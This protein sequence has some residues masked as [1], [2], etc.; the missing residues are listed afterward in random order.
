MSMTDLRRRTNL[1]VHIA[2]RGVLLIAL[3]IVTGAIMS[4]LS[5]YF[6]RAD[7]LLSMTQYGTIIGLLALGQAIVILGGGG[8]IDLSIGS[9][10]SL[11]AVAMGLLT[12]DLG[13]NPWLAA[14]GAIV[15]GVLLGAFNGVLVAVVGLPP[16]IV[17][18][19]TL[20]VYGS[21]A[22]VLTG[23]G[24]LGGFDAAGFPLLG[25]SAVLGVPT[26]VLLVLLPVFAAAI[27]AQNRSA[28]GRRVHQVGTSE[29]AAALAGVRV[30]R[31]R[32]TLYCIAGGLAAL[33][34]VVS[35]SWLLTARPG[36]GLD[37]ELQ[38]IT[39]AVL[40]GI[41]IFGGRGR[42]SGVLIAVLLVVVLTSGLQLA[43]V[44]N[45]VQVGVLGVLLVG[46]ALL[47]NLT[48]RR[49]SRAG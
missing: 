8:G 45:S 5:P 36:A 47:N 43:A 12:Q 41:H 32:F 49:T 34:A 42:L 9:T 46:A 10:M 48:A 7:N 18:L 17:T 27:W 28:F 11:S 31:L 40:G 19:S 1:S 38:A 22:L 39:V 33:A 2:D 4:L 37:L 29:A 15:A 13:V 20:F 23:G 25:Q 21:L 26:Q 3:I 24:Q 16:L 44:G 6:L 30:G 14:L 35:N